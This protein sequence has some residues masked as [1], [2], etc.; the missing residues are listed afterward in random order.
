MEL[1][2]D[3]A[4]PLAVAISRHPKPRI[5]GW[6]QR[7]TGRPSRM[8]GS[9][10][11]GSTS[12]LNASPLASGRQYRELR[13]GQPL[14]MPLFLVT[15]EGYIGLTALLASRSLKGESLR[16]PYAYMSICPPLGVNW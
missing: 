12:A 5:V 14:P 1:V 6:T 11:A 10:S 4:S 8:L 2:R 7:W 16:L 9:P 15:E 3:T 13:W